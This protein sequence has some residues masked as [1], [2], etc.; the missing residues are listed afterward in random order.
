[1]AHGRGNKHSKDTVR[2][3]SRKLVE[4]TKRC[5][6]GEPGS[7]NQA[8]SNA[9]NP[10]NALDALKASGASKTSDPLAAPRTR[11]LD[12]PLTTSLLAEVARRSKTIEVS[13]QQAQEAM[14]FAPKAEEAEEAADSTDSEK[15]DGAEGSLPASRTK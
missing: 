3:D 15:N 4:L 13:P 5:D 11:T 12:D 8:A 1:M 10:P 7:D 9:P 6:L 2:F 14:E